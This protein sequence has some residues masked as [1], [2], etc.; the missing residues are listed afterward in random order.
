[1]LIISSLQ[2]NTIFASLSFAHLYVTNI[3]KLWYLE[4]RGVILAGPQ[5][6]HASP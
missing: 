3:E 6:A 4:H 2:K 5:W 1:M